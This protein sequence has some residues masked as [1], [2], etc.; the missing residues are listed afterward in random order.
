MSST[1]VTPPAAAAAVPRR[2]AL[3]LGA[4]RLVEVHVRVDESREQ[5]RVV[6]E[7]DVGRL[8][9]GVD[10]GDDAV[11]D[12]DRRSRPPAVDEDAPGCDPSG[13]SL[14]WRSR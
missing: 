8:V 5:H 14:S 13:G 1:V 7:H 4:P 3:P 2:E 12:P 11:R 9:E 6:R 10:R